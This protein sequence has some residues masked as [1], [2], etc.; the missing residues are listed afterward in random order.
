MGNGAEV[1]PEVDRFERNTLLRSLL[2]AV[3]VARAGG[4]GSRRPSVTGGARLRRRHRTPIRPRRVLVFISNHHVGP[5]M[6]IEF[7]LLQPNPD[8]TSAARDIY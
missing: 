1:W 5:D 4:R 6:E 2:G 7:F 8:E 3:I